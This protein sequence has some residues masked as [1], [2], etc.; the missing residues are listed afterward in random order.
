MLYTSFCQFVE[1]AAELRLP[2]LSACGTAERQLIKEPL[3]SPD[4]LK[5]QCAFVGVLRIE[6]ISGH[7]WAT[8]G[9]RN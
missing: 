5:S 9:Y 2:L 3:S 7:V 1:E 6:K 8:I 4:L